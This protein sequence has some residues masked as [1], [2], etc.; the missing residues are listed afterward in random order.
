[1]DR[2]FAFNELS[3]IPPWDYPLLMLTD[4]SQSLTAAGIRIF[5]HGEYNHFCFLYNIG[6]VATQNFF[7]KTVPL[8]E[9]KDHKIKLWHNPNWSGHD[10][11]IL[12]QAIKTDLEKSWYKR[13]YDILGFIGQ[14]L[15]LPFIQNPYQDFCSE[16]AK[17]LSAIDPA[18]D[19]KIK[20]P[21]PPDLNRY[22][23]SNPAYKVYGRYYPND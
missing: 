13:M 17:Y 18:Y 10:K 20:S 15:R 22:F 2:I 11:A 1:M 6:V 16:K 9:Y 7:F 4:N 19:F 23:N 8:E 5:E 21:S 3:T 14:G 12:A